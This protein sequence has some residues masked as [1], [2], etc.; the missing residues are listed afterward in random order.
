M[1][2]E[3]FDRL[4]IEEDWIEKLQMNVGSEGS[5][6]SDRAGFFCYDMKLWK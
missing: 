2:G 4:G 1:A 3:Y 5:V 6:E